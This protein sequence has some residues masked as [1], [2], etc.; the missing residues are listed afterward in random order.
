MLIFLRPIT[1]KDGANI[2]K[3][4]NSEK[5]HRDCMTKAPITLESHLQYYRDK[6][7]TGKNI[8]FIVERVEE[9]S[10]L[11]SYPIATIYLKDVDHENH[12]CELCVFTS[13]DIEWEIESQLLAIKMILEKAF[14]EYG[15]HKVYSRVFYNEGIELLKSAGF[16]LESVLKSEVMINGEYHDIYRMSMFNQVKISKK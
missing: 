4:R 1:E 14:G 3:W 6:V 5:V 2:V 16:T 9:E 10:G 12:C 7:L 11:A 8:Q 15:M 13:S